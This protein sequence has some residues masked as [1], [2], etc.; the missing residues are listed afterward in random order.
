MYIQGIISAVE[1]YKAKI[2]IKEFDDFETNWLDV[3]Q[4]FTVNNKSGYT[5]EIG[6]LVS[7]VL[8][9]DMTEGAILGAIYNSI[10]TPPKEFEGAEFF[11]FSDGVE[12]YHIPESNQ[13]FITAD[14]LC[15]DVNKLI[16][17]GDIQGHK[18]LKTEGDI[19]S[20]LNVSD[21]LGSMAEI[22]TYYNSHIHKDA[23]L[24]LTTQPL[25]PMS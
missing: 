16:V 11:K 1:G 13:L 17:T 6:T 8:S 4:L 21:A 10:D 3:P 14:I 24:Q 20:K 25:T 9:D 5:P 7:A 23:N 15:L 19:S 22:R 12:V 18:T 2:I